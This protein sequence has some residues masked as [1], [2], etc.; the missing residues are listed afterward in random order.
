MGPSNVPHLNIKSWTTSSS[1][2]C[3]VYKAVYCVRDVL[4]LAAFKYVQPFLLIVWI[5]WASVQWRPKR[6]QAIIGA[7]EGISEACGTEP[8]HSTIYCSNVVL[9]QALLSIVIPKEVHI[10][11]SQAIITICRQ[12]VQSNGAVNSLDGF[13]CISIVSLCDRFSP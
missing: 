8:V 3:S 11:C 12:A 4:Q 5:V 7:G 6:Q 9:L 1:L 10:S 2:A 13:L